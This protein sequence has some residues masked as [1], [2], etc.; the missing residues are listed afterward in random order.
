[1]LALTIRLVCSLA[2]VVGLLLLIA[3]VGGRRLRAS[4]E[5]VRVLH[6]QP[7]SRTTSVTVVAVGSRVLVLGG[8]EQQITLL[9]ELDADELDELAGLD[10]LDSLDVDPGPEVE[11]VPAATPV[12]ALAG[13]LLSPDTWRQAVRAATGRAR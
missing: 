6:R 12:G 5:L 9:A 7:L 8:T 11:K 10:S 13:S 1:M 4:G 2:L 3:R